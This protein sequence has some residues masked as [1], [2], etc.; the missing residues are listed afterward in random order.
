M[1]RLP[2][3]PV[4]VQEQGVQDLP[5]LVARHLRPGRDLLL[6][7]GQDSCVQGG[8][9]QTGEASAATYFPHLFSWPKLRLVKLRTWISLFFFFERTSFPRRFPQCSPA[10]CCRV[11]R[12]GCPP[13]WTRGRCAGAGS[14][15][16]SATSPCSTCRRWRSCGTTSSSTSSTWRRT[17]WPCSAGRSGSS[18]KATEQ[19]KKKRPWLWWRLGQT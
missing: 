2:F 3:L 15:A 9:R 5:P 7:L 10:R 19:G 12:F 13:G 1:G 14:S 16:T 8:Q 6:H 18:Y 4:F 11:T 17:R